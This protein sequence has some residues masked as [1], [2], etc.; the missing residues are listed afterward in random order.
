MMCGIL[1]GCPELIRKDFPLFNEDS[2]VPNIL[3]LLE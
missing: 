1:P 2:N 3:S